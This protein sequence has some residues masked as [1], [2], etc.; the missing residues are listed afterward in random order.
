[1]ADKVNAHKEKMANHPE[2]QT[3]AVFVD[4]IDLGNAV[5]QYQK[6]EPRIS[7]KCA[8]VWQS[9]EI[10]PDTKK[11]FE[12]FK[13]YTVSM[14]KKAKLRAML[15]DVRGKSYTEG[16]A[17]AGVPLERLVGVNVLMAIEHRVSAAGNTYANIKTITGLPKGTA[18]MEPLGYERAAFWADR[19]KE[20]ASDVAIFR[21][22]NRQ[23]DDDLD[24][25]QMSAQ[26]GDLDD[27]SDLP[28]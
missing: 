27:D 23:F 16:E 22:K 18:K 6:Q 4:V 12:P 3:Q 15:E 10:N 7:E 28:F 1:M 24:E 9:A 13:E 25:T 2:G 11:R 20:Y 26:D 21:K 14:G 17:E 5:E 19:K 8:I